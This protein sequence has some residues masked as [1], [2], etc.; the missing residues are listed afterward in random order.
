MG[1]ADHKK[2]RIKRKKY[3]KEQDQIEQLEKEIRELKAINRSLLKQLKKLSRGINKEAYEEAISEVEVEKEE[4]PK[5]KKCPECARTGGLKEITVAGRQ[6][7]R[8]EHCGYRSGKL[9]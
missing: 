2:R 4:A 9:N 6:F 1:L 3:E 5:K 8:C 7:E